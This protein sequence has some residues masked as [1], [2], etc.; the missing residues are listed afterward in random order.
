MID[1][2]VIRRAGEG[3]VAILAAVLLIGSIHAARQVQAY[4]ANCERRYDTNSPE[5]E[6]C[7]P[8]IATV[9]GRTP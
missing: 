7:V 1:E 8:I 3:I 4:F 9:E 2:K 5:Y 6:R